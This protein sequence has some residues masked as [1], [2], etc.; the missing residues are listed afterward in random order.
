MQLRSGKLLGERING[1]RTVLYNIP[2]VS[3]QWEFTG[4]MAQESFQADLGR[5][6]D[7]NNDPIDISGGRTR[8]EENR[9]KQLEYKKKKVVREQKEA[10]ESSKRDETR[11]QK[12][13]EKRA[14]NN[15]NKVSHSPTTSS[16]LQPITDTWP[17]Q[18]K[19]TLE[20]RDPDADYEPSSPLVSK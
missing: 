2:G 14:R 19:K 15:R 6:F 5:V 13:S 18:R 9:A 1:G 7:Q 12:R 20:Q 3:H 10:A 4:Y 11:R 17:A 8:R 16:I